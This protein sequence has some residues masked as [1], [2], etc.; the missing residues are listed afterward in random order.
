MSAFLI[1]VLQF[2]VAMLPKIIS[3]A[4]ASE[5]TGIIG[6]V[7]QAVPIAIQVGEDLAGPL[8]N[9]IATL[10]GSGVITADQL[11]TLDTQEAA[12][13]AAFDAAASAA[14]AADTAAAPTAS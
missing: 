11:D 8:R 1:Q 10:K 4:S 6:I 14:Q 2:I 13:D 5:I 3:A 12:L 9:I 7:E